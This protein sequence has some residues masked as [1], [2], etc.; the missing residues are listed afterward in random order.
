MKKP[1]IACLTFACVLPLLVWAE[2]DHRRA[3]DFVRADATGH[4]VRLSQYRG[5]VV[6]LDFWA[7][8]CTGCKEEMP[9]YVEFADKY[10]KSGLAVLGVAMDDEGWSM[11]KPFLNGKMKLN[12]P[13]VVGDDALAKQFGG[14]D[15]LPVTLL[16]DRLGNIAYSHVGVVDK[17]KFEGEIQELLARAR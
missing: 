1:L 4:K 5:K 10:R 14:I 6:L 3:P 11:V 12:Y 9:W 2:T 8:W 15:A 16:I 7:T 17:A 13:V